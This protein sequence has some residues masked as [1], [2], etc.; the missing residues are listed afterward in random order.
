MLGL[1]ENVVNKL[2]GFEYCGLAVHLK[3]SYFND[4]KQSL[5]E[6]YIDQNTVIDSYNVEYNEI[7]G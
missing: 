6:D 3:C 5:Y 2:M 7:Y 4:L 1:Q